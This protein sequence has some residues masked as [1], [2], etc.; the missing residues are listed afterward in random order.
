MPQLLLAKGGDPSVQ[1]CFGMTPRATAQSKKTPLP[2]LAS[3]CQ[4]LL[5]AAEEQQVNKAAKA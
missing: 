2:Q 1:D 5:V 4:E 3:C